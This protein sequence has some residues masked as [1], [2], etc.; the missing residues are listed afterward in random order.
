MNTQDPQKS[1][2]KS[3][4]HS[5]SHQG[6]N[7]ST[8]YSLLWKLIG[9]GHRVPAWIVYSDEY[10]EPIWDLVEVKEPPYFGMY[11]IGTRGI[12]YDGID[13]NSGLET[14]KS[15]CQ[16]LSLHFVL[17]TNHPNKKWR[18]SRSVGRFTFTLSHSYGSSPGG[19]F[20]VPL[21]YVGMGKN[22]F[23]VTLLG[24]FFGMAW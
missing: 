24:W 5:F 11:S 6:F 20:H 14:F 2:K 23:G 10:P 13:L 3:A 17:S 1:E 18:I 22:T 9:Q 16:T 21:L 8:D 4:K 19:Y 15:I 7:L 12:S